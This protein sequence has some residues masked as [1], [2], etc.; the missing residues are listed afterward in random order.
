[1]TMSAEKR[2][3]GSIPSVLYASDRYLATPMVRAR[4]REAMKG[5]RARGLFK[6][7]LSQMQ[8]SAKGN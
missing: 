7:R 6:S 1:M 5:V 2:A 3:K 4:E 8:A